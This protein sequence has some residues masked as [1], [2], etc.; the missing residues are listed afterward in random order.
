LI[1]V[2]RTACHHPGDDP[3]RALHVAGEWVAPAGSGSI[4]VIDPTI[5]GSKDFLP[6]RPK[7]QVKGGG[8][9]LRAKIAAALAVLL[10]CPTGAAASV[11]SRE[12]ATTGQRFCAAL[13]PSVARRTCYGLQRQVAAAG[14]T[15]GWQISQANEAT[16]VD[17][18]Q[19]PLHVRRD[20]AQ[21]MI[22]LAQPYLHRG[23]WDRGVAPVP[24]ATVRFYDDNAWTGKLFVDAYR[25]SRLSAALVAANGL[26]HFE[27]TGWSKHKGGMYWNTKRNVRVS[28]ATAGAIGLAL[29][30]DAVMHSHRWLAFARRA[31]AW[32]RST[33]GLPNGLYRERLKVGVPVG[34]ASLNV[35]GM[36]IQNGRLLA[37]ATGN[38]V[39]REQAVTTLAAVEAR[40]PPTQMQGICPVYVGQFF[41]SV[42]VTPQLLPYANWLAAKIRANGT[43]PKEP[44]WG[45]A[46]GINPE[47]GA[48]WTL[49]LRL[50]RK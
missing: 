19:V 22:A 2:R 50:D 21:A 49:A 17:W 12:A 20:Y 31:Y 47:A 32:A 16:M 9:C 26:M 18:R 8:M 13:P 39:F 15:Y 36:M 27:A 14:W 24:G 4:E 42:G 30:L 3:T 28:D 34:V 29:E 11:A 41:R 25:T 6:L 46:R 38:P 23:K 33:L 48:A 44:Y 7:D 35:D 40:F 1:S 5:D 45:K 43:V 37:A 10:L